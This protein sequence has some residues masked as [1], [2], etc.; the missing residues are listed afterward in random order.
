MGKWIT[1]EL[2]NIAK[3]TS[4][5]T[6]SKK[7]PE[8]YGGT[9]PWVRSGELDSGIILDTEIKITELGLQNSSAKIFP[10]G[11]LLIALYG[12]TIGKL[13]FLGI[14]ACTNQA[15]C[16][17]F[18]NDKVILKYLYYYLLLHRADL[19]EQGVGGAQPNISQA[20]LKK[21]MVSYPEDKSE[22]EAIVN[23]I[24]EQISMCDNLK[25]TLLSMQDQL[26]VFKLS[27]LKKSLGGDI[28]E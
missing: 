5:G 6:P 16:A 10:K 21:L 20:I 23:K 27:L 11:T 7:H 26:E 15:V 22:Q 13:G 4:G 25:S 3:T 19:I 17:I 9:I 28:N 8:Y 14:D 18:E 24:E 1:E 2:G 12:A